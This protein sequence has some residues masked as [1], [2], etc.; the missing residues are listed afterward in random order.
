MRKQT[1]TKFTENE[2]P[3]VSVFLFLRGEKQDLLAPLSAAQVYEAITLDDKSGSCYTILGQRKVYYVN[4]FR[5]TGIF[6]KKVSRISVAY[7]LLYILV[8]TRWN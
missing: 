1:I 4:I 2:I 6:H 3:E 8:E 5:K 7:V